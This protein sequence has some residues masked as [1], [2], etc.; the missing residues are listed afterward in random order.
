MGMLKADSWERFLISDALYFL[1]RVVLDHVA[2][3]A[4]DSA[5]ELASHVWS[6][7]VARSFV[8]RESL[9]AISIRALDHKRLGIT[10]ESTSMAGMR[11]PPH[12][13]VPRSSMS[14]FFPLP[15]LL[16]KRPL[17][18]ITA[19]CFFAFFRPTIETETGFCSII[20]TELTPVSQALAK[21][22]KV[23]LRSLSLHTC[24]KRKN[25]HIS[26]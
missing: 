15:L 23:Y 18:S 24:Q 25:S 10:I 16:P 17:S 21:T 20:P 12:W 8:P 22:L 11:T 26:R 6:G 14:L 2:G 13:W 5:L 3:A 9:L 19:F 1:R 4:E 7:K